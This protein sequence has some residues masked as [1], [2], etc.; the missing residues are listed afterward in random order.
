MSTFNKALPMLI[1]LSG[2]FASGKDTLAHYLTDHY[3]FTHMSTGDMVRE[4]AMEKYGSIE[5][6]VLAKT[7]NELRAEQGGGALVLEA[8]KKPRPLIISGI[9]SLGEAKELIKAGGILVFVDADANIRYDRMTARR[10]DDETTLSFK[11]F[12]ANEAKEMKDADNT[13]ETTQNIAGVGKLAQLNLTNDGTAAEFYA[14]AL[15]AL[16]EITPDADAKH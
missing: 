6:P 15:K 13:D 5:R 11:E 8:M 2:T 12:L 4:V 9:R 16:T 1:G 3:S 10:R 14:K 7:A